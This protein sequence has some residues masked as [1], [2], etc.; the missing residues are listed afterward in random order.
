ME[1]IMTPIKG[2]I[3][4]VNGLKISHQVKENKNFQMVL[5]IKDNLNM[6]SKMGKEDI[7]PTPVFM[8]ATSKMVN[9]MAKVHLLMSIIENTLGNGKMVLFKVKAFLRGL[10]EINIKVNILT[11]SNMVEELF[12]FQMGKFL[13]ELGVKVKNM[14]LVS[15]K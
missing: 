1:I 15:Y 13:K 4:K 9:L 5:T 8:K 12:I 3:M 7:F 10:T 2:I 6:A 14:D 11:V